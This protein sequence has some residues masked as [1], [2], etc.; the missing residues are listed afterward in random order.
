MRKI[1]IHFIIYCEMLGLPPG[2]TSSKISE[3]YYHLGVLKD[4]FLCARETAQLSR[5]V[6]CLLCNELFKTVYAIYFCTTTY[7]LI[8]L[9]MFEIGNCFMYPVTWMLTLCSGLDNLKKDIAPKTVKETDILDTKLVKNIINEDDI[10]SVHL[11][12]INT[13]INHTRSELFVFVITSVR[14]R[15]AI[16]KVQN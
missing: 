11:F 2:N 16:I 6:Q 7:H 12:F 8:V 1:G 15:L 3:A 4:K 9:Y 14:R 10:A 13:V 5:A